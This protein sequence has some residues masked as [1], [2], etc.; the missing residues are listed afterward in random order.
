M[1]VPRPLCCRQAKDMGCRSRF[2]FAQNL[3][4][5]RYFIIGPA[6]EKLSP[7]QFWNFWPVVW[8]GHG[9]QASN[10]LGRR[11]EVMVTVAAA[12][13]R[14]GLGGDVAAS[15]TPSVPNSASLA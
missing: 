6:Q 15:S 5:C 1:R 4:L 2:N 11:L 12:K 7:L 3:V 13:L 14:A 9:F 10:P 8:L